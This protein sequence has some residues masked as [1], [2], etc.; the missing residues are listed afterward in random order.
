VRSTILL[1]ASLLAFSAYAREF[2][3]RPVPSWVDRADADTTVGVAKS[4][5]RWGI[6][7]ILE[8]HQVRVGAGGTSHFHRTVRKVLSPSGVQ[9]ASE[10]SLDFDP[11]Y[12]RLTLHEVAIVRDGKRVNALAPDDVRVIDK[13]DDADEDIYDG[14]RTALLFLK[15]VRPGDVIDYAWSIDG[16]NPLLDGRYADSYDL[17]SAVPARRVRCRLLYPA[18]RALF[19]RGTKP[20]ITVRGDVQELVWERANVHALD[21]EDSIPS[22]Y[23]PWDLVQVTDFA[24]WN[25]VAR[26]SDAM[27]QPDARSRDAVRELA[28]RLTRENPNRDARITA[29][30]RF[31]QDDVRYLGIEFGRNSHEPHQPSET[32]D[33][34][35]GDCKDKTF[36]LVALLR[37]L[38]LEAYPALV[39][40]RLRERLADRLP[41]PFLFDHVIAEVVDGGRTYWVDGT[42]ADQGGTLRT[43]ETPNDRRAL[44]VRPD[45]RSLA[46]IVTNEHASTVVDQT[47]TTTDYAKPTRLDVKT[48]YT[49]GDA[50][51]MRAAL[52]RMSVEDFAHDRINDLA[53]DQPKI[54]AVG[55]PRIDD[56]RLRNVIAVTEQY[57]VPDLWNDGTWTWYPRTV[58]A[59]FE[60]PDTMIRSMPLAFD[61]PL[62]VRQNV[63]FH[64]PEA[65]E[66]EKTKS[67]TETPTF[68]YESVVDSD[69]RSIWLRRSLRARRDFVDVKDVP[70]H[71]TQ[72]NAIWDALGYRLAPDGA[73][74][75]QQPVA[76]ASI[77]ASPMKWGIG[78]LIVALVVGAS[79]AFA[80]RTKPRPSGSIAPRSAAF[81]PGEAPVS[82]VA[83]ADRT[84]IDAHLAGVACSCGI[85]AWSTPEL[86][87][88]RYGERDMTIVTRQCAA[89]G[90]EQNIY[91]TAA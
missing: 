68:R 62:D 75:G 46:S 26:W 53:A 56:D 81:L 69:G 58:D 20:Q 27:F 9:N 57:R 6:Y 87:R 54:T 21:V 23:E 72:I 33:Q 89:C 77:A 88:A 18:N 45:T 84:G 24:S 36:L 31:V 42:I 65:I 8:D 79:W 4:N 43:L 34:R 66:I 73:R 32:L 52:A 15:D 64:L 40:T 22:W 12:E 82:A 3:V 47:Y 60:R 59:H 19:W 37:E 70:E 28:A 50:D 35:Y 5:V 55:T 49:G 44:V 41:S 61:Y 16:D 71:L 67:V 29:A 38:G 91:F 1:L 48:T 2:D 90:R 7:D 17:S 13:E 80:T 51:D 76:A 86:Q 78:L 30:I 83:V 85:R 63:T 10:L 14:E 39:N 25:D 11:S 74:A